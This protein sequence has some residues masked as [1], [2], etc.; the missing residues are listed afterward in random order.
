MLA[1]DIRS[2]TMTNGKNLLAHA[3]E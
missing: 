3:L 1:Y 2:S